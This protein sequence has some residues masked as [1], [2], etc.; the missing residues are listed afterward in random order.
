MNEMVMSQISIIDKDNRRKNSTLG[1]SEE[2]SIKPGDHMDKGDETAE[3]SKGTPR[4]ICLGDLEYVFYL[5]NK[6]RGDT[7]RKICRFQV[8]KYYVLK[9]VKISRRN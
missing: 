2:K 7:L 8:S 9:R 3:K 6:E 1:T 4:I 5:I